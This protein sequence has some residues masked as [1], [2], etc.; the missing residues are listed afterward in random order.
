MS[1]LFVLLFAVLIFFVVPIVVS[2]A[3][4]FAIFFGIKKIFKIKLDKSI[5]IIGMIII[6]S[7]IACWWIYNFFYNFLAGIDR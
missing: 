1:N 7:A 3:I 4:V 5:S 6:T 2:A